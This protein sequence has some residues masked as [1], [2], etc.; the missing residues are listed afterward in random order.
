MVETKYG[1]ISDI[2]SDPRPLER[3]VDLLKQKGAQKL[4]LNGDIGNSQDFVAYVVD[5]ASKSGLETF[6]QPGSHEKLEDFE[7]VIDYMQSKH[8]NLINATKQR[9]LEAQDHEL[10]FLPGTDWFCGG[11]YII[12]DSEQTGLYKTQRGPVKIFNMNDLERLTTEPGKT[13]M[14]SHIPRRFDNPNTCV[15]MAYFAE[16]MDGS[17]IPGFLVEQQIKSQTGKTDPREIALIAKQNGLTL[18]RENRGN[19]ALK[20]LYKKLGISKAVSGHFHESGHR[21]N[22]SDE[23]SV[24]QRVFTNDLF[25][26]TGHF[27]AGQTGILSVKDGQISYENITF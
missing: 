16:N 25:W 20:S 15:D 14:I 11:E 24:K 3:A 4:I 7:P 9:K 23:K 10:I 26:N 17:V 22:D 12:S 6:A 1:I 21:A 2:H 5:T 13:I 19:D 27:D 8:K 18:K